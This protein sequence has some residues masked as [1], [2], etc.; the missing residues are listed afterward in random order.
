V[1]DDR[2]FVG[3]HDADLEEVAGM[4]GPDQQGEA[5]VEIFDAD[6]VVERVEDGLI[7]DTVLAGAWC[8]DGLIQ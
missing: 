5:I 6:R 4:I 1:H 3:D 7:A 8:E 2:P